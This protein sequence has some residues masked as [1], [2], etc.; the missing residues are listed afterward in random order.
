MDDSEFTSLIDFHRFLLT[1]R[2]R[3]QAYQRAIMKAVKL[4]DTVLDIGAGT[5]VLSLFACRAGAAKV[6]AVEPS[7]AID[8]AREVCFRNGC[9]DRIVFFKDFFQMV[10]LPDLVDVVV[11]DTGDT[12]GLQGGMLGLI[13][14]ARRRCLRKGGT[15]L[16]SGLE[17]VMAPVEF[18]EG[19]R[20][21][22]VWSEN[23]YDIDFS[24]IRPF[25][26]N[27]RYRV[28]LQPDHLLSEP[29]SVARVSFYEA[30]STF[31]S[32]EELFVA[33][34]D[35]VLHGVGGWVVTQLS[36]GISFST[37]PLA[38]TI[39]WSHS[40][41]PI[42][43]PLPI[44]KGDSIRVRISTNDGAEWRWRVEVY[45]GGEEP[46][47]RIAEFDQ[48]TFFGSPILKT[49][50]SRAAPGY[51]PRISRHGEVE[52][53]VLN[54]LRDGSSTIHDIK[55]RVLNHFPNRCPS[56]FA[57]AVLVDA[58]VDRCAAQSAR[59]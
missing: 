28:K 30:E 34:R 44:Q 23:L 58:I 52:L 36:D 13:L 42:E 33:S 7:G 14:D 3:T 5:G 46:N 59:L 31:V 49:N 9:A 37:S 26:V 12:F 41:F 54:L 50:L 39:E 29:A 6:Y 10:I 4:G 20:N 51:I 40:F 53:F 48:S 57:A 38:P 43:K 45:R 22:E 21:I 2:G 47:R 8:L 35:G 55:Q 56:T 27:G 25:A 16:P 11:T 32:G 17:L 24:S 1:D 19:S 18:L 15:I